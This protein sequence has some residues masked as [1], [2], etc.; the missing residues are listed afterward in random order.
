MDFWRAILALA[1]RPYIGLPVL[2]LS[3]A[4]ASLAFFLTP[5]RYVSSATMVLITSPTGGVISQDPTKPTG[6]SNPLLQFGEGLK[7]TSG[8]LIQVMNTP[9]ALD[10]IGAPIGGP[11]TVSVDGG[12]SNPSLLGVDG[13]FLYIQAEGP[14]AEEALGAVLRA[15]QRAKDELVSR[16]AEVGAPE[17]TYIVL[18]DV[19]A[20]SSPQAQR[21]AKWQ[22]GGVVLVAGVVLGM[23]GAYGAQRVLAARRRAGAAEAGGNPDTPG[24]GPPTGPPTGSPPAV[25]FE[26]RPG[27]AGSPMPATPDRGNGAGLPA[28]LPGSSA[29]H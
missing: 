7:T 26:P 9:A 20:A 10:Q 6:L 4:V 27:Q 13:P 22:A 29:K 8:I 17:T 25:E 15:Q 14:S 23:A 2:A 16:Q 1:R 18:A 3:V 28:E 11:V 24:A 5:T 12:L 21:D 19:V